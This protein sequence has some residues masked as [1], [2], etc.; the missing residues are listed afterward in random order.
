MIDDTRSLD[1][2]GVRQDWT[3]DATPRLMF[4]WGADAKRESATYDYL[5]L[6]GAR[7]TDGSRTG[8]NRSEEHT[9]ELQSPCN[10]VCRLLPA[11]RDSDTTAR[12]T[13]ADR[14]A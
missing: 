6:L 4:K 7:Q 10:L 1:R 12:R 13:L 3:F 11:K 14:P 8:R 5:R 9:S 2:I